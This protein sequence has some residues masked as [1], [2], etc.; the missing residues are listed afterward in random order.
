[1]IAQTVTLI[2]AMLGAIAAIIAAVVSSRTAR[3][4]AKETAEAQSERERSAFR[5]EQ[6]RRTKEIIFES[7][8]A[9]QTLASC[10][11]Y[12]PWLANTSL[13]DIQ[14]R[15]SAAISRI[16]YA[17]E[18]LRA[19]NAVAPEKA[20][21]QRGLSYGFALYTGKVTTYREQI[22]KG[23]IA[24]SGEAKEVAKVAENN[25]LEAQKKWQDELHGLRVFAA[26]IHASV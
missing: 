12:V 4:A 9:L 13:V 17:V 26:E 21:S 14:E 23:N 25:M 10:C 19:M 24:L 15:G 5:R 16:N 8:V 7:A 11:E 1:M 20:A 22:D 2:V 6:V 3:R 18:E